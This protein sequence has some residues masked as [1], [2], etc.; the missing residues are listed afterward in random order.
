MQTLGYPLTRDFMSVKR[1]SISP[2]RTLA[3]VMNS[4]MTGRYLH[5]V[6]EVRLSYMLPL[7]SQGELGLVRLGSDSLGS[8]RRAKDRFGMAR[9]GLDKLC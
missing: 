5:T 4:F 1:S 8:D 6:G 3:M 9:L 7:A 2:S